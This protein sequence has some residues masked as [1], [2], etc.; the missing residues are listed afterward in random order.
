MMNHRPTIVL[1]QLEDVHF[2][3]P[4]WSI[5]PAGPMFCLP[6]KICTGLKIDPLRVA[7]SVGPNL[8]PDVGLTNK[9]IVARHAAIIVQA[10]SLAAERIQLLSDL[11]ISRIAGRDV[12]L[13]VR[14]ESQAT[15]SMELRRGNAFNDDRSIDKTSR[16]LAI[17]NHTHLLAVRV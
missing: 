2:I 16:G 17:A 7:I 6:Q 3:P 9:R 15:S 14:S 10:Q 1:A 12:E 8:W 11:A 13:A 4:A 5:K